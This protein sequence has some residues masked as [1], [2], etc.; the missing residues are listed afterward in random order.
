MTMDMECIPSFRSSAVTERKH[1][2]PG[3]DS[4]LDLASVFCMS[5][6][7]PVIAILSERTDATIG[8]GNDL[9]CDVGTLRLGLTCTS[10]SSHAWPR[11][12]AT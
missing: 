10:R 9:A 6:R 12:N 7:S 2:G 3:V 5:I 1:V 4:S 11:V 8:N